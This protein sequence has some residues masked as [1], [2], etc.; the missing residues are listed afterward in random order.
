MVVHGDY[1]PSNFLLRN[2]GRTYIIDFEMARSDW[3][4]AEVVDA[5]WRFGKD[6][7]FGMR[8]K[9]I[10]WF[11]DAYQSVSSLSRTEMEMIPMLWQ[12]QQ[13]RRAIRRWDEFC[14]EKDSQRVNNAIE[15]AKMVDWMTKNQEQLMAFL[16]AQN[17]K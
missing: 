15:A 12:F 1:S 16:G 10:K 6:R 2:K 3:R 7:Y 4:A 13:I 8:I 17:F 14:H 5:A 9:K 11:L